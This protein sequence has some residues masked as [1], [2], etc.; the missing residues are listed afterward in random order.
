M[1]MRLAVS[2]L[3]AIDTVMAFAGKTDPTIVGHSTATT[4]SGSSITSANSALT[5]P[6][7]SSR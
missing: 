4:A 1:V 3:F 5:T 2:Q 6:G 7:S